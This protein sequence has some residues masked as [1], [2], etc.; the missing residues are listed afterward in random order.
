MRRLPNKEVNIHKDPLFT[1]VQHHHR[2]SQTRVYSQFIQQHIRC[3]T[4]VA[5]ILQNPVL[6]EFCGHALR[7]YYASLQSL[8]TFCNFSHLTKVFLLLRCIGDED[9]FHTSIQKQKIAV[10]FFKQFHFWII[11]ANSRWSQIKYCIDAP[12]SENRIVCKHQAPVEQF[13]S[14][15]FHNRVFCYQY[16]CSWKKN[17]ERKLNKMDGIVT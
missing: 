4:S 11:T 2:E 15:H 1:I 5:K 8:C 16:F 13:M 6:Q 12:Q 14:I 7:Q 3:S 17:S 9:D 10:T